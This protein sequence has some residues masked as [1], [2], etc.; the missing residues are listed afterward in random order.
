LSICCSTGD[1]LLGFLKVII[2]TN[3]FRA[4]FTT[5]KPP[6]TYDVTLAERSAAVYRPERGEKHPVLG[7]G[8]SETVRLMAAGK[9]YK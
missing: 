7:Y 9:L 1:F 2:T 5:V 4:C 6:E 3:I 8:N